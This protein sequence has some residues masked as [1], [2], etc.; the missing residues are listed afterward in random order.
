M[1]YRIGL[2]DRIG[3][4]RVEALEANN[5]PHKWERD[6][7]IQIRDTYRQK[8]KELNADASQVA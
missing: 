7:L 2:I 8:R 1:N 3:L 6:E 5:T 4:A